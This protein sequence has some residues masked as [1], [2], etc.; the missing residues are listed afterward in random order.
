MIAPLVLVRAPARVREFGVVVD[1]AAASLPVDTAVRDQ[2]VVIVNAPSFFVSVFGR[3]IQ[4]LRGLP[5]PAR[6]L[7]LGSGIHPIEVVRLDDRSILVRPEG[8]FLAL[9][10][11]P[12]PGHEATQPAFD[13]RYLFQLLDRLYRDT[14]LMRRGEQIEL[15][16]VTVEVEAVTPDGRPA[17]V[18]F[19][20]D[21]RVDDPSLR[22]LRWQHGVYV[23]FTIPAVGETVTL[24]AVTVPFSL[25]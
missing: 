23:P 11:S 2:Q 25:S 3:L 8:G 17:G 4:G 6:V 16:G 18:S 21:R 15:T 13:V 1:R 7:V 9:P 14:S 19:R 5:V 20:F 24:P 12:R 22:W 10:G